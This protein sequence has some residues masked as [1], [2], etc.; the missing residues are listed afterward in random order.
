MPSTKNRK[1]VTGSERTALPKAKAIGTVDPKER[2]QIT[3]LVR[4]QASTAAAAH[5]RARDMMEMSSQLPENR[6]YVSREEFAAQHGAD[7]DD[8]AK[9]DTFAHEHNLTVIQASI[10]RRTVKLEGTIADLSKAFKPNLKKYKI[11][12]KVF[13]GRT[14]AI[15]VPSDISDIVVGVFGF[16]NRPAARP[17]YRRFDDM[18]AQTKVASTK[19]VASKKA[20]A[21]AGKK[22]AGGSGQ[23]LTPKNAPDGSFTPPEVAKL[24]NFPTGFNGKGQCIALIELNDFDNQG[25]ITGTGFSTADLKKYFQR[26]NI[27]LPQVAAIGVD[28]GANMPGPD[29]NA[30][31]EV[32]LDIEVAGAIAPGAKIAVYFAPNTFQGF[33]DAVNAAVHDNVRQPSVISISWGGVEDSSTDQFRK[34]MDQAFQDAAALG[35]TICCASGDDGSSD[36]RANERDGRPHADFPSSSPFAL[37][38]GGTKLF[39]SGTTISSEVVWNEGNNGGAGGGG[40]SNFFPRPPYQSQ[41]KVPKSPKGKVGRGV[42]DVAGDADPATGYQVRA[43][44]ADTVIGGTSAV[45]PLWAGLMALINQ[46]LVSLGKKPAGFINALLYSAPLSLNAFHDI[47]TGNNDIDGSFGKYKAQKGWDACTGLGTPDGTKI[48]QILGG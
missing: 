30:D 16:D 9:I 47:V 26:L 37:A 2:I 28:G 4:P 44:G 7:P 13:R 5:S 21:K 31:G 45:A 32:M 6:Q 25:N 1:A 35:V 15:S 48:M 3:V 40:V 34:G 12:N 39:G 46:R 10:P 18:A 42:P 43:N 36:Q 41:S 38:C 24:Y 22:K 8:L 29:P 14:G 33:I 27:P 17:H 11:G 23:K 19:V 20:G